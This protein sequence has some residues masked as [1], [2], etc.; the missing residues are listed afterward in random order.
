MPNK[1]FSAPNSREAL[2]ATIAAITLA[3]KMLRT[4]QP[5][6]P[7]ADQVIADLTN[8]SNA[9]QWWA[10][11]QDLDQL[12][13]TVE[14]SHPVQALTQPCSE[15]EDLLEACN[16]RIGRDDP[17]PEMKS[18]KEKLQRAIDLNRTAAARRATMRRGRD[19]RSSIRET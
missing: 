15:F 6:L 1:P 19:R 2:F 4:L 18:T 8:A 16:Q 7:L 9:L 13:E 10:A 5:E 14:W 3:E 12:L 17:H 11:E